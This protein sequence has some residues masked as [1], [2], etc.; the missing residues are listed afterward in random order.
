M[1]VDIVELVKSATDAG[2]LEDSLSA[3]SLVGEME[4]EMA[5]EVEEAANDRIQSSAIYRVMKIR[6]Q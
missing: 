4:E 6:L 3:I 1:S 2:F 5:V